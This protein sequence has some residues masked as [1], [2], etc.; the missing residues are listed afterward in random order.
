MH[1]VLWLS[2]S[3][4]ALWLTAVVLML[5]VFLGREYGE[6]SSI[7]GSYELPK[8]ALLRVLVGLMVIL[9]AVEWV[10]TRPASSP[11]CW[12]NATRWPLR[13]RAWLDRLGGWL[14]ERP[15]NWLWLAVGLYAF[16]VFISTVLSGDLN[17][18]LWGD[19]PGQDSYS[20]Y[21]V[22]SYI[23]LFAVVATHL[24][25]PSQLWRL[26]GAISTVGVLVSGYAIFQHY[27]YDFLNLLEPEV[28]LRSTSAMGGPTFAASLVE[29]TVPV[30]LLAAT[31]AIRGPMNAPRT[32]WGIGIFTPLVVVQLT[33]TVFMLSRGPWVGMGLALVAM[34]IF[35]TAFV[36]WRYVVKTGLVLALAAIATTVVLVSPI[37]KRGET[38]T[39]KVSSVAAVEERLVSIASQYPPEPLQAEERSGIILGN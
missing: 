28:S 27:G 34:L 7:I 25:T 30:S 1:S 8:I 22:A 6:W 17:V 32:W 13:P 16:S 12:S 35:I 21:T 38:E 20:A 26:L 15:V 18:S 3:L 11:L 24:K 29:M 31:M 33:G 36:G 10:F 39:A 23:V 5:L 9:W 2:R 19:V 37:E 4:E 14:T